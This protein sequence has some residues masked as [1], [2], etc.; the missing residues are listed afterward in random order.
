[1]TITLEYTNI[2]SNISFPIKQCKWLQPVDEKKPLQKAFKH[3]YLAIHILIQVVY[4]ISN[5]LLM[6]NEEH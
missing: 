4:N 2:L 6:T 5:I 1:M 3:S